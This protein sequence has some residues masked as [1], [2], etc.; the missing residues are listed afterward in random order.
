[1]TNKQTD[2]FREKNVLVAGGAGFVGTNL[3]LRLLELGAN[4]R[5]TIHQK[6]PQIFIRPGIKFFHGDLRDS[7]FAHQ[8][9]EGMDYVFMCAANTSGAGVIEKTPLVHVTP[10]V[11][12]NS[13]MLEAAHSARVKKFL[14]ISS[15]A[16]YPVTDHPVREEEMEF[17][18]LFDKY[19]FAGWMK[20]FSEVM[21]QMYGKVKNPMPV[22]VVRPANLYGKY[23]DFDWETSH[24]PAAIIRKVMEHRD[25][26]EV[27]GDGNSIKDLLY[28]DDFVDGMLLAMEKIGSFDA[29]NIASG[30]PVTTKDFLRTAL[31]IEKY[32]PKIVFNTSKPSMIPLRLIDTKKAESLLGLKAQTTLAEG[33]RRTMAWYKE[34]KM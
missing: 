30:I 27:W 1:M 9:A 15:N 5:A 11:I 23:D 7:A 18:N 2:F 4:V 34:N 8:V 20:Q 22:I 14:F 10:N 19:F 26:L 25:P 31:Q 29:V 13:L 32:V 6:N 28:I 16:V 12:I 17:G 33:V 21:C 24:M 3:I